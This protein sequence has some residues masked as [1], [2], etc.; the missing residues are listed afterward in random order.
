MSF[1]QNRSEVS[2]MEWSYKSA[3]QSTLLLSDAIAV[4]PGAQYDLSVYLRVVL[5]T[6]ETSGGWKVRAF[7]YTSGGSTVNSTT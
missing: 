6:G 4:S 7:F 5:K 2:L 3:C 1:I